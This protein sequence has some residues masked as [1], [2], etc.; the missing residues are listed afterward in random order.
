MKLPEGW[1]AVKRRNIT[2]S[3]VHLA[4]HRN[5][6]KFALRLCQHI[7]EY[8]TG[9]LFPPIDREAGLLTFPVLRPI[10]CQERSLGAAVIL[11]PGELRR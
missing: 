7:F 2:S 6:D 10:Q 11:Y 1:L 8:I 3:Q 4:V 9:F 5:E